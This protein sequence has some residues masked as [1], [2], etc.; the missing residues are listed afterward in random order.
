MNDQR[1]R[2]GRWL[3]AKKSAWAGAL[4]EGD[5]GGDVAAWGGFGLRLDGGLESLG[6]GASYPQFFPDLIAPCSVFTG[7]VGDLLN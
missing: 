4:F 7:A 1:A 2:R 6:R 3:G 5:V